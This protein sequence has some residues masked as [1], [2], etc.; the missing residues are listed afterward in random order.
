M[1]LDIDDM[2]RSGARTPSTMPRSIRSVRSRANSAAS[3]YQ[4]QATSLP[5]LQTNSASDVDGLEPLA[6]EFEPGSFDLVVPAHGDSGLYSLERR[7][8]LLFSKE[9]L[10]VIFDDPAL[11]QRFT[12]F[13][14]SARPGSVPLLVYYL[15]ALKALRAIRYANA[16][17][18][19]LEPLE[20]H[21]FTDEPTAPTLNESLAARADTAFEALAREDLPAYITHVWIQTVSLSIKRRITGTLPVHLRDMS[22]GL[23]E[24]FCLTDPSRHDNPIVLASEGIHR[25]PTLCALIVLGPRRNMY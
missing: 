18:E 8:E 23:A 16:V 17:V 14:C 19:A 21:E 5:A 11:L 2:T 25:S 12:T 24:V 9:H 13:L 1:S 20:G 15:D 6:E 4:T 10:Q 7:S 3:S 22:E